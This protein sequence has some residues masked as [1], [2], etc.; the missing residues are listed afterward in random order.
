MLEFRSYRP[1]DEAGIV[2]LFETVFGRPMDFPFWRWRF[3]EH[4]AGDPLVALAFDG[5]LLVG[6]YATCHAPLSVDG[7]RAAAALSMTT[8][9]HPDYRGRKL[10]ELLGGAVYDHMQ[11]VGQT[12]VYGFPNT[13]SHPLF[14]AKLGWSDMLEVPTLHQ[15]LNDAKIAPAAET[16]VRVVPAI[17][18]RFDSLW[19]RLAPALPIAGVRDAATLAWRVDRNPVNTY[20]RFVLEDGDEIA[21]YA[22]TKLYGDDAV[23]LVDLRCI[24]RAA[25]KILIDAVAADAVAAGR[26]RVSTWASPW[27]IARSAL[28]AAGYKPG[29]PVTYFGGRAFRDMPV[30]F[31]DG[32]LWRLSMLD[33]DLY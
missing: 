28:E 10:F 11:S 15:D 23:D 19:R 1:G 12:A 29:G 16:G 2:K 31:S 4:P 20:T 17:D 6:H 24:D 30:D 3:L 8:M 27:D 14:L 21:G 33:S 5:D 13:N 18:R 9:T 25:A 26:R 7:G 32:R 22:I